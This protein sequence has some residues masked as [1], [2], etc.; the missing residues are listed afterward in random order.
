MYNTNVL[1]SKALWGKEDTSA[2]YKLSTG[3][4]FFATDCQHHKL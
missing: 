2:I 3:L 1:L 4:D